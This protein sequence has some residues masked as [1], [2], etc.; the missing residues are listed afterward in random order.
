MNDTTPSTTIETDIAI[1]TAT[2][3]FGQQL[4]KQL[5]VELSDLAGTWVATPE[6]R[7]QQ[8]IDRL[9]LEIERGIDQAL[10]TVAAAGFD[11]RVAKLESIAI[12]DDAKLILKVA[13]LAYL[14]ELAEHIGGNVMLVLVDPEEYLKGMEEIKAQPDQPDLPLAEQQPA[15]GAPPVETIQ[16]EYL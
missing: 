5:L 10:H 8:T 2:V 1:G 15:P 11:A 12:K 4:L 7:Q 9:K 16:E 14:D 6:A 3:R 13:S